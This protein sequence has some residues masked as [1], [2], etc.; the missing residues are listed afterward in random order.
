MLGLCGLVVNT[1]QLLIL[2]RHELSSIIWCGG[3]VGP[4]ACICPV[5][6]VV[7]CCTGDAA[8]LVR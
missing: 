8:G 5:I 3:L 4:F 6:T 2:E 7:R 1:I